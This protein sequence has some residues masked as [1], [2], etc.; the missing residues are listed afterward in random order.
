MS[1][2][3]QVTTKVTV[4]HGGA[5]WVI[6]LT[7]LWDIAGDGKK[8]ATLQVL[9]TS[10]EDIAIGDMTWSE[11]LVVIVKNQSSTA[12]ES[13]FVLKSAADIHEI[14]PGAAEVFYPKGDGTAMRVKSATGTPSIHVI[15]VKR[16]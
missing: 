11:T 13:V 14:P 5:N 8:N 6:D 3:I 4:N 10:A 7:K 1:N 2:E 16:A 12:G 9:S 15:A